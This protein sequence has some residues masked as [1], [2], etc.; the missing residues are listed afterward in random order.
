MKI[1]HFMCFQC[2]EMGHLANGCPNKKKSSSWRRKKRSLNMSN[3]SSA[4]FGVTSPQCAQPSNWWSNKDLNQSHKLS[5]RRHPKI[6]SRSTMKI[7]LIT[8]R[9]RRREW[10]GVEKEKGIK[11]ISKMPRWW[12][13]T[14]FKKRWRKLLTSNVIVVQHW[15]T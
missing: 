4:T 9:W 7:K 3:A 13:R 5:K 2:H 15:A 10:E 11:C 6:K 12:V 8:W 1:P 14:R